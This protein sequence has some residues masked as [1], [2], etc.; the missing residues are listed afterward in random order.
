MLHFDSDYMEGAHPTV[1]QRL[2]ET[3]LEQTVGYGED[4]YSRRAADLIR[5]ACG[6]PDALVRFLVGGTQTNATVIDGLLHQYEGVMA[7]ETGHIN[8]FEAGAVES[9]GHKILIVPNHEGKVAAY[10]V[11]RFLTDFYDNENH[12]HMV[13]PGTIHI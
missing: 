8:N 2:L 7:A 13:S 9:S 5:E 1:M 3:N 6:C 4:E 12:Q 10:D 11:E